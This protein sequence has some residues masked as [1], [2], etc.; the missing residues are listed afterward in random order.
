MFYNMILESWVWIEFL[1]TKF[2]VCWIH[3]SMSDNL[4]SNLFSIR[5]MFSR[6]VQEKEKK[7]FS[8]ANLWKQDN[9]FVIKKKNVWDVSQTRG[10]EMKEE[11]KDL[12][13]SKISLVKY[14]TLLALTRNWK[15][16]LFLDAFQ[17]ERELNKE[18]QENISESL[19]S[20]IP[21][22]L[23]HHLD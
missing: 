2:I 3:S 5:L 14:S 11:K 20:F 12:P 22:H 15:K 19:S 4:F 21:L 17:E 7:N 1:L 13:T 23:H 9:S 18:I 6:F 16:E 8:Y 10:D